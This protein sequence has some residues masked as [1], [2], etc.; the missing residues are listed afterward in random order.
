MTGLPFRPIRTTCMHISTRR[1]VITVI[2]ITT[3]L[4]T[5]P[6]R[7]QSSSYTVTDL[8]TLG[9]V[10]SA[11]LSVNDAREVVG[12]S[13]TAGG[14]THAFFYDAGSMRDL[15]TFGGRDSLAYGISNTGL[16]VGRA[17][18]RTG[19]FR[20]FVASRVGPLIDITRRTVFDGPFSTATG[21]NANGQ[22][23]GYR[24]TTTEHLAG[25][26]RIFLFADS[27]LTDLGTFGGPD[28]VVAGIN[29]VGQF[30]GFY[31]T[32]AH[33]DYANRRAFLGR[34]GGVPVDLG[35][36]GGRL[37]TPTAINNR[38]Q[39]A[40]FGQLPNGQSHAF[41]HA[42]GTLI[43]LGTL[44][45]GRQSFGYG[46]DELGRVVGGSDSTDL[47][48]HAFLHDGSQMIDLNTLIPSN[49]GWVLTEARDI[50]ATGAIV[51]TGVVGGSQRAFLLT[52]SLP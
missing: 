1:H 41:L 23:V 4:C 38:G 33:A 46:L 34:L 9:G 13:T 8:G 32:E 16:I 12:F 14:R 36:L 39:V 11:A 30:V 28:A 19:E 7:A 17:Q 29:D 40:G 51:G 27:T 22:V 48:F 35:T 43:D 24:M 44:P 10:R 3:L 37:M 15:G 2:A 18:S 52:P 31:G 26:S 42:A 47:T 45:G 50:N 49:S 20:A 25:R 6:G 5:S 21:V